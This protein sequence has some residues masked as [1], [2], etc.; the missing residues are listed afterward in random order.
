MVQIPKM[1][2][3]GIRTLVLK[4]SMAMVKIGEISV[5]QFQEYAVLA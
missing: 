5:I 1:F 3:S 2:A 4:F